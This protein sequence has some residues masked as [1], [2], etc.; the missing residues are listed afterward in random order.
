M[1]P[2]QYQRY[3]RYAWAGCA[4]AALGLALVSDLGPHRVWGV[5]AGAGYTVAAL[6]ACGAR[7]RP[8]ARVVAVVG[9]VVVPLVSLV[10]AGLGQLEVTV[11]ERSGQ[12]LLANG[13]PYVSDPVAVADFNPY[14][15]GMALFGVLPGDARWWL[16]GAFVAAL[17]AAGLHRAWLLAC[18]LVALPLAVGGIDLPVVGLMCL[19]VVLAGQG[20]PGRAGLV[21]GAAAAL[22]WTAWPALPVALALIA[23]RRGGRP[24]LRYAAVA[25]S[26][27]TAAVLP[28]ALAD[29]SGLYRNVIAF[30]LGLT[31][32]TSPAASPLPGYLLATYVPGGRVIALVLLAVSALLMAVSLGVRPPGTAQAAAARLALGLGLAMALIP[33]TRFGYLV[34]PLVLGA[35]AYRMS[36]RGST[37][38]TALVAPARE[39]AFV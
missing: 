7:S 6:L 25:L 4:V 36:Q 39:K 37:T 8:A 23:V 32:T 34:C 31:D 15:P 17:A 38:V 33:A 30:P 14:L 29:P 35:L 18:P 24:A 16:G 27:T 22:K 2:E 3:E 1:R 11:V 28:F 26:T 5:V 20:R 9:A 19:G 12:L 10:T 21:L 13:S